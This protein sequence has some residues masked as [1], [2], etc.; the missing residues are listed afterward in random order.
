MRPPCLDGVIVSD[1][2]LYWG[3]W[4]CAC[5][6]SL[7]GHICLGPAGN[8]DF[9]RKADEKTQLQVGTGDL[10][11]V[12]EAPKGLTFAASPDGV[13]RALDADKKTVWKAYTGGEINF[14]P[15]VWLN[16]VF[17]GSND[18]RVYAL[19][20]ATGRLLWQFQAAPQVR[21]IHAYGKLISTWP[22]AGGVVVDDGVVYAAAGICHYDGT[23]VYALDAVTGKI[24]WHNGSSGVLNPTAKNGVSLQGPLSIAG[25]GADK[26]LKFDGGNAVGQATFDLA[27]GKCLTE[28]PKGPVAKSRSTFY[29]RDF[30]K[31]SDLKNP[32]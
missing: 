32:R 29:L 19:E 28:A 2:Y 5:N 8:F 16:R 7:Y 24:K 26:V 31:E 6:L 4:I 13:V 10:S 15:V 21:R 11:K 20:A 9:D 23:H 17:A 12:K 14:P 27:T 25:T 22:V 1:G 3:P 18:G 30:L